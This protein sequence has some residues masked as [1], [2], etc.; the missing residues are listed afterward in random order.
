MLPGGR[1]QGREQVLNQ[2]TR[3]FDGKVRSYDLNDLT[4]TG[5]RAGRASGTYH[6]D[7]GE[8]N[9]YDGRIVFGVVRERGEPRIRL[10]AA[11]PKA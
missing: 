1:A 3:Q 10:I 6:V 11:T 9:P 2:Y 7:R 8:G 5:G 4:V